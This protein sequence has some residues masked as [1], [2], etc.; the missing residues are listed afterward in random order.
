M[1]LCFVFHAMARLEVLPDGWKQDLRWVLDS[2]N[3]GH[4]LRALSEKQQAS[5]DAFL[6]ARFEGNQ[7][8]RMRDTLKAECDYSD[9]RPIILQLTDAIA[10]DDGWNT[11]SDA[12]H[13][14]GPVPVLHG[15]PTHCLNR[16]I[17]SGRLIRGVRSKKGRYGVCVTSHFSQA[18]RY[19]KTWPGDEYV[20]VVLAVAVKSLTIDSRWYMCREPW[21]EIVGLCLCPVT[22]A[23]RP[24]ECYEGPEDPPNLGAPRHALRTAP[25]FQ[26]WS[27]PPEDYW[28]DSGAGSRPRGRSAGR[29]P[30]ST[31]R[32]VRRRR[33]LQSDQPAVVATPAAKPSAKRA[34]PARPSQTPVPVRVPIRPTMAPTKQRPKTT[35]VKTM[36]R[37]KGL[38]S[39]PVPKWGSRNS[40]PYGKGAAIPPPRELQQQQQPQQQQQQQ[41]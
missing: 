38:K 22:L 19:S 29:M 40:V 17:G 28:E 41:Q 27:A 7:L 26:S 20:V 34:A 36:A 18:L 12:G 21:L 31:K 35:A 16:L 1:L 32:R 39:E 8:L 23:G 3:A 9:Y 4:T 30:V 6:A 2:V 13:P 33:H 5:V 11:W 24:G 15:I 14:H 37:P 10:I 25:W